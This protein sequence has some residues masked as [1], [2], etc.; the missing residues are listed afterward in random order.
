MLRKFETYLN[1]KEKLKAMLP[2]LDGK[3][4]RCHMPQDPSLSRRQH[5]RGLE[6]WQ[7]GG[8]G[9]TKYRGRRAAREEGEGH[10]AAHA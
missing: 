6:G 3:N 9:F 8:Q 10:G 1:E 7:E 5:H 4:L 2:D